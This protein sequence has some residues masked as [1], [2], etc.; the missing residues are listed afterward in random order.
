M[1]AI[2]HGAIATSSAAQH[3]ELHGGQWFDGR[4]FTPQRVLY[5]SDGRFTTH[6]PRTI[7]ST[8]DLSGRFLVTPYGEAHNHNIESAS[9]TT[10][11]K[12]LAAGIFYVK[13]PE[14]GVEARVNAIG[15]LNI[16]T[17]IDGVF[18]GPGFT[19]PGGHPSGLVQRNMARGV[20]KPGSDTG[21]FMI[22]VRDSVDFERR[23]QTFLSTRQDFVKVLLLYSEHFS[24]AKDD[25]REFN[26]HG[27]DPSLMPLLVRRAHAAGLRVT[28]HVETAFDFHV[29]VSAGVDEI[30]HLPG[31]R[32]KYDSVQAYRRDLSAYSIADADVRLAAR[33]GVTVVTTLGEG[34]ARIAKGD[35]S[36]L[37]SASRA[38]VLALDRANLRTLRAHG[39]RIAFGS[40]WFRANTASEVEQL[41]TLN[42]F[43]DAD[44]IKIWS[45][46]TPRSIFPGRRIGC[47]ESGCDA[48]FLALRG[49]P[50]AD[51]RNTE[52]IVLRMKQGVLLDSTTVKN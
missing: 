13:D 48:S 8:I 49:D 45:I 29:A 15:V 39:V 46:D 36:G 17:S 10:I 11:R 51:F 44:L 32:P 28:A 3:Y 41:R 37:D 4:S 25:P 42:V 47:I 1:L 24:T 40:D 7:D 50:L 34:L 16:P 6:R 26:W 14:S 2:T 43:S 20:M 5:V 9:P 22:P 18:A 12:Y 35:S 23:W 30:A 31:F 52:R 38:A 21:G 33:R 19:S 27:F